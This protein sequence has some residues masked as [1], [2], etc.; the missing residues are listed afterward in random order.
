M[1]VL[2]TGAAGFVGSHCIEALAGME[3][4]ETIAALRDRS[5]L[6]PGFNGKVRTGDFRTRRGG[7]PLPVSTPI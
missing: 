3:K 7:L 4:V 5:K 2:V 6:P 1:R